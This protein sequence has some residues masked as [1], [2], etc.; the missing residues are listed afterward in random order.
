MGSLFD[1]PAAIQN[2]NQVGQGECGEPVRDEQYCR[3]ALHRRRGA[4]SPAKARNYLRFGVDVSGRERIIKYE[5]P[6]T[7][8]LCTQ[9]SRQADPLA[10]SARN[11][12]TK[13]AD[14][15]GDPLG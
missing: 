5:K 7:S 3:S 1:D 12:H 9:G 13:L 10:L 14:L 4:E 11:A 2:E 15:S 6:G 8:P